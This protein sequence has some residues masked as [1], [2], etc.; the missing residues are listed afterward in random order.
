MK[1]RAGKTKPAVP[2]NAMLSEYYAVRKLSKQRNSTQWKLAAATA[3]DRFL[4][5]GKPAR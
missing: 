2:G 4:V 3:A 5:I 1:I